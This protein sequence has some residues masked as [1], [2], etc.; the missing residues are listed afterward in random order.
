[1]H[2]VFTHV[3]EGPF[4]RVQILAADGPVHQIPQ[5]ER[6]LSMQPVPLTY[7]VLA[8]VKNRGKKI[9]RAFITA[10]CDRLAVQL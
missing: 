1:M 8:K 7:L 2:S 5:R 6:R 3:I 9:Y 10:A 4:Y